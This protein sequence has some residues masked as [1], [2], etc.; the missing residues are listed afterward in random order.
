M[1]AVNCVRKV[2]ADDPVARSW[3]DA[4]EILGIEYVLEKKRM[5]ETDY[6]RTY[7]NLEAGSPNKIVSVYVFL[8]GGSGA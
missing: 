1:N 7:Y 2:T 4:L 8:F 6:N 5:P 3:L